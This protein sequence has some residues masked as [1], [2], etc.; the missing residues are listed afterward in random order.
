MCEKAA[1]FAFSSASVETTEGIFRTSDS[2]V[3]PFVSTFREGTLGGREGLGGTEGLAATLAAGVETVVQVE[4]R[5]T[6]F[7]FSSE[8]FLSGDTDWLP[9]AGRG[10]SWTSPHAGALTRLAESVDFV[11]V[12][13]TVE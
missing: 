8:Y 13:V 2:T 7:G 6:Y 5:L 3:C 1:F 10:G 4:A 9:L 11:R 12:V